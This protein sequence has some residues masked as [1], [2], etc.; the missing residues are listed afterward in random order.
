MNESQWKGEGVRRNWIESSTALIDSGA[1]TAIAKSM[2][3]PEELTLED[4]VNLDLYLQS[5][6]Y[7][8]IH[9]F[10]ASY[11]LD[12]SFDQMKYT[13]M[14]ASIEA[15]KIFG[16]RFSRA[17]LQENSNWIPEPLVEAITRGLKGVPIGSGLA[18]YKRIDEAAAGIE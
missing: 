10:E 2:E 9:D 15:P 17:W 11:L 18:Y 1:T 13:L 4:K 8:Y 7:G 6:T 16:S 5:W 3:A 14:E 12:D